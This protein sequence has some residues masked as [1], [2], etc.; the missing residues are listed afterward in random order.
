MNFIQF[1]LASLCLFGCYAA[2]GAYRVGV[3][4][5]DCTGPPV[6]IVFVRFFFQFILY[7]FASFGS[8]LSELNSCLSCSLPMNIFLRLILFIFGTTS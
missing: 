7:L 2:I 3:G 1:I 4:R 6:E 5:A 8:L